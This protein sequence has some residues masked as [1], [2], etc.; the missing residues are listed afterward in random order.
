[1]MLPMLLLLCSVSVA[2]S[3]AP[4]PSDSLL[5]LLR[6]LSVALLALALSVGVLLLLAL[7]LSCDTTL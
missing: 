7:L 2:W 1:M 4:P 3:E 5:P 6:A